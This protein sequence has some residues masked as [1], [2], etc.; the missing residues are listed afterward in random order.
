M[1]DRLNLDLA[2]LEVFL[3]VIDAGG[4]T[5][6]AKRLG[7]TQS[8]VS[9]S[10][11]RLERGLEA[12]LLDRSVRPPRL[13]A[14]GGLVYGQAKALVESARALGRLVREA[15]QAAL[16]HLRLGL[17]D[18]FAATVGPHLVSRLG[19]AVAQWSVFSGLS[20]AHERALLAREVDVIV[21]PEDALE[22]A[23]DL[24][25]FELLSEP[26]FLALPGGWDGPA[27][28]L[29]A[30]AG[31]LDLVRYSARS[32]I[33]R[34][35]ERHLR[36]VQVE[37]PRRLEFDT[38]DAA[39]AMVAAGLGFA[40]TTPLCLLQEQAQAAHIRFLPLPGP[41]FNRR[42]SLI[43]RAHEFGNLPARMA[44][45]AADVLRERCLPTVAAIAPWA[46]ERMRIGPTRMSG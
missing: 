10:V 7:T 21:A 16:P 24:A 8:A 2:S 46:A 23:Q 14:A 9:Q 1:A 6:A 13:T 39:F 40:I 15:D 5:A 34:Q 42:L 3:T 41:G 35:I 19:A 12:S 17:I 33:G 26:Y 28:S 32:Q 29:A 25:R 45:A 18:S 20:P 4:M 36:R 27:D 37:P 22:D 43:A 11:R 44:A 31:R 38:T 30:L